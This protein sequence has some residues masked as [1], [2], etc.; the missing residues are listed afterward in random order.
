MPAAP[1]PPAAGTAHF[2]NDEPQGKVPAI[3][4]ECGAAIYRECGAAI[5]RECGAAIYRECGAAIYR[6]CGAAIHPECGARVY[7][8]LSALSG[9]EDLAGVEGAAHRALQRERAWV[10]FAAHAVLFQDAHAVLAGYRAAQGDGRVEELLERR[11]GRR[12][13]GRVARRRDQARVQVP[14]AG[15]RD[16]GGPHAVP[17]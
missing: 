15:V 14:V 17:G 16:R 1:G 2:I 7:R 8:G 6:E 11:L 3:H 12:L 13:G 10:E 9:V 4:P 5:Y